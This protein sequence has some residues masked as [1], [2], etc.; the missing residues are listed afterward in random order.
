MKAILKSQNLASEFKR[1]M[2]TYNKY[3]WAT[4]WAGIDSIPFNDLL[5]HK[6]K[7]EKIIVGIHFYQTHPDFIEAFIDNKKVRFIEQPE[8]TF[9]PKMYLF[10]NDEQ[11]WELLIGSA[12][13]TKQ[14]FVKNSEACLLISNTDD[15]SGSVSKDILSYINN[16]FKYATS[17]NN[18]K[19]YSYRSIWDIQRKKVKSLSGLYSNKR[20]EEKPIYDIRIINCSWESFIDEVKNEH[21]HGMKNRLQV[22]EIAQRIFESRKHFNLMTEDERKFIAGMPNNLEISGAENWGYFGSMKG[23][24]K[25]KNKIITNSYNISKALDQIPFT[26]SITRKHYDRYINYFS[27]DLPG[28][29]LATATRLL[30][31]KRPDTFVCLD[32]RNKSKLCE[33]FGIIQSGMDFNRY[34]DDIIERINDSNWW[35]NPTPKNLTEERVSKARAA[36]LDSLYYEE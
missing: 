18:T 19:L 12:N 4:A 21:T 23:A 29:Y 17:F 13:F 28:N 25:Y 22:I 34:W 33:A 24:G 8:G 35:Q 5:K 31:M 16:L 30:A 6:S 26:G 27:L 10:Y 15:K 11:N 32:S 36:F 9:H 7:I 3:Y 2:K 20:K 1:L 14:A